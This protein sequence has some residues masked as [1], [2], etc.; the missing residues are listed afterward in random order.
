MEICNKY[1]YPIYMK[2]IIDDFV[3]NK[4]IK[5]SAENYSFYVRMISNF[6][7]FKDSGLSLEQLQLVKIKFMSE[8]AN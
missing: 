7:E 4:N 6:E 1:Y 5:L 8:Y 3:L 2:N